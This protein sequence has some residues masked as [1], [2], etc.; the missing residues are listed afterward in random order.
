MLWESY[1][2]FLNIIFVVGAVLQANKPDQLVIHTSSFW[3][4]VYRLKM[5]FIASTR[6]AWLGNLL[7]W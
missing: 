6:A 5:H 1:H 2:V 7:E 4:L 3:H